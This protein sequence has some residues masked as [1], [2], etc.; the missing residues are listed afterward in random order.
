MDL[1]ESTR[2]ELGPGMCAWHCPNNDTN[3]SEGLEDKFTVQGRDTPVL[4]GGG[5]GA[6]HARPKSD[7]C[8]LNSVGNRADSPNIATG[9]VVKRKKSKKQRKSGEFFERVQELRET[10]RKRMEEERKKCLRLNPYWR[11]RKDG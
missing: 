9:M 1:T 2:H 7:D 10:R 4:V 11:R 5:G 3:M 6:G 8:G